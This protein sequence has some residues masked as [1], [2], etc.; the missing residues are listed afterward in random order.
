MFSVSIVSAQEIPSRWDEITT[1]DWQK[2]IQKS[3]K[4]CILPFGILEKHGPHSPLGTDLIHVRDIAAKVVQNEYAVTFPDYYFG[5][6]NEARQQPGTVALPSDLIFKLLEATCDEIG[7]NGFDKIVILNGHGGNPDFIRFFMQSQLNKRKTYA[8]YFYT[9]ENDAVFNKSLSAMRKSPAN[10]DLH[11][12]ESETSILMYL[13]PE[14]MR[15][16]TAGTESGANM[17]R[18][19]LPS[20]VYTPI[21]WY[22]GYPNH[23]AGEG[24]KASKEEGKL[25]VDYEVN[26][27]SKALKAIKAD[28]QTLEVQNKYYDHVEQLLKK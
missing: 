10:Q 13:H 26:S 19:S 9:P 17:K 28:T 11:A 20:N 4:T 18:S 21:W 16:E 8:V 12:G 22:A 27:F 14:L 15:M 5:Q 3:S 1:S 25:I 6:I 2:A 23:Y 7:R 24:A